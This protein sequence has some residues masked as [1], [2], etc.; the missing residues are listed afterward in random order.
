MDKQ[1][2]FEF[3]DLK[4]TAGEAEIKKRLD[5]KLQYF[6]H[7]SAVAPGDFLQKLHRRNVEK[8]HAIRQMFFPGSSSIKQPAGD[9]QS[10]HQ[11]AAHPEPVR[12]AQPQKNNPVAWLIRHTE[13][14][15]ARPFPLYEGK[16][17]VGRESVQ[18]MHNILLED[19]P[20]ISRFHAIVEVKTSALS[21]ISISIYDAGNITGK[22]SKN[23]IFVNGNDQRI[24]AELALRENDTIQVGVTKMV[25]RFNR[26]KPVK[27]VVEEVSKTEY[28]KT[29][30]IDLF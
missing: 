26:E 22:A 16:N 5:E 20:Y 30:V 27:H 18:N 14:Q 7:L 1:E 11:P 4:P 28:I 6:E 21:S 23:G 8:V 9:W 10:Q 24:A 17:H 13:E 12:H 15:S 19:D 2:A 29:V 25:L 3:L